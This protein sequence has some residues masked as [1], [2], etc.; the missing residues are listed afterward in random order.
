M[1]RMYSAP[2][3]VKAPA[4]ARRTALLLL[5]R[6]MRKNIALDQAMD[7]AEVAALE[8]R[9]RAF[10]KQLLM[11]C[12]KRS[13][14]I[15]A[16]VQASLD[17]PDK[18]LPHTVEDALALGVAQ[19]LWMD[20]PDYA[21][22][23]TTVDL[24]KQSRSPKHAGLANAVLKKINRSRDALSLPSP[25]SNLPD[26]LQRALIADYGH[27]TAEAI[28][29]AHIP[30]AP[31][32]ISLRNPSFTLPNAEKL[33]TGSLRLKDA[34]AVQDLKGF[35]EGAW[36]VQ[37]AAAALPVKLLGDIKG[38]TVL[39]LCAAPGGKTMQLAAAGAEVLAVDRSASRLK[40]VEGNLKRTGLKATVYVSDA[41]T[42][43]PD[44]PIDAIL[45]DAPCSA[46]G[47]MR[48]HPDVAFH[49]N[50]EDTFKLTDLQS[51]LLGHAANLLPVGGVLV[52]CVC[53]LLKAEGEDIISV[54]LAKNASF[55]VHQPD[56]ASLGVPPEWIL[57]NGGIRTLPY[58]GAAQGGMDGF[59]MICLQKK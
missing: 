7:S 32:D 52:Y 16:I 27:E 13:G 25:L 59:F 12:L 3:L 33:P 47:T 10:L 23:D 15:R 45:L 6:I 17:Q 49:R 51:S 34:Q 9:D 5:H 18:K 54:F 44:R 35:Q 56:F 31:L 28:S 50:P 40:R 30:E 4:N 21:A 37:D 20:V 2:K 53:S 48:R 58:Y 1:G 41:K 46:T 11:L 55:S 42:F 14:E 29:A 43:Q 24:V 57:P 38:K 19:L 36:W 26:W 39:D 22:I 8:G